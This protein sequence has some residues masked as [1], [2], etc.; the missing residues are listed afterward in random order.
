M[1]EERNP[2]QILVRNLQKYRSENKFKRFLN[3]HGAKL[4]NGWSRYRLRPNFGL[5]W[6]FGF[7]KEAILWTTQRNDSFSVTVL[8]HTMS[9]SQSVSQSFI[10]SFL[11]GDSLTRN[12]CFFQRFVNLFFSD[13]SLLVDHS[14]SSFG[15]LYLQSV[16]ILYRNSSPASFLA[17][18]RIYIYVT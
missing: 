4:E 16:R 3:K 1:L 8:H 11:S 10:L 17:H 13:I 6:T 9:V 14:H 12:H 2:F 15:F 5:V 7:F 18:K